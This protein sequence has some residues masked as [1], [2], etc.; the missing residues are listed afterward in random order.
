M[1]VFGDP[2]SN[3]KAGFEGQAGIWITLVGAIISISALEHLTRWPWYVTYPLA[4]IAGLAITAG[5]LK[6]KQ[7]VFGNPK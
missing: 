4:L 6:L 2:K 7:F 5:Y 1:A 3:N